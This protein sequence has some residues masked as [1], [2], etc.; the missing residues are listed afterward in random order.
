M[1]PRRPP[2]GTPRPVAGKGGS[3]MTPT[4]D[5]GHGAPWAQLWIRDQ[6]ERAKT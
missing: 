5:T 2:P 6:I 3:S 4:Q 1:V